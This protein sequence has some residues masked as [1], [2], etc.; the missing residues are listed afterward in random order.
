MTE[1]FNTYF[2][3]IPTDISNIIV[4][5]LV[6]SDDLEN[7]ILSLNFLYSSFQGSF[8]KK[9][10]LISLLNWSVVHFLHFGTFTIGVDYKEYLRLLQVEKL[11]SVLKLGYTIEE[12]FNLKILY[13]I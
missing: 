11:I 8:S 5:Y 3:L 1:Y 12:L 4:S 10:D 2:D 9:N 6:N 13:Y 7:F